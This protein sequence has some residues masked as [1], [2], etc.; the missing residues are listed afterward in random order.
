M[1]PIETWHDAPTFDVMEKRIKALETKLVEA[2]E[3]VSLANATWVERCRKLRKQD[4]AEASER[5]R[6]LVEENK[7][8]V[9]TIAN[10][11]INIVE[12]KAAL[13]ESK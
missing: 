12:L 2:A 3:A 1:D 9:Q 4:A 11:A 5:E 6:V 8:A 13:A 10:M 7:I